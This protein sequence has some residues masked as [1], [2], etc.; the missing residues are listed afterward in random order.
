[1]TKGEIRTFDEY[2][3]F[4]FQPMFNHEGCKNRT[5]WSQAGKIFYDDFEIQ[6]LVDILKALEQLEGEDFAY[7]DSDE[8]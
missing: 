3:I 2:L 4:A 1:M 8:T 7:E 6:T 5:D